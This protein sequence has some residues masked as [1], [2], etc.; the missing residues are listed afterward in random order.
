M[1]SPANPQS[2][3]QYAYVM[4]NPTTWTD[5]NGLWCVWDDGSHDDP[6][7]DDGAG[8]MECIQQGGTWIDPVETT[9]NVGSDGSSSVVTT[10]GGTGQDS[11]SGGGGGQANPP[12]NTDCP[13]GPPPGAPIGAALGVVQGNVQWV[14]QNHNLIDFA[15]WVESVAPYNT[16]GMS[17]SG[18]MDY[19][20]FGGTAAFGNFNYGATCAAWGLSL[21][22]CQR[23]AGAAAYI[24]SSHHGPGSPISPGDDHGN[25]DYGDQPGPSENGAVISGWRWEAAGGKCK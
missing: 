22:T 10:G 8:R 14:Q 23:G 4:N 15:L 21:A 20:A 19:K 25:S 7:E 13:G 11:A 24:F 16:L 6:P 12:N 18:S 17:S 3:N 5:P 9:A 1:A 2:W